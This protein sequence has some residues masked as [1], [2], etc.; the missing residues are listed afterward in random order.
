MGHWIK[1][2]Q[3]DPDCPPMRKK[4]DDNVPR[5]PRSPQVKAVKYLKKRYA[6]GA[7]DMQ[8]LAKA[9]DIMDTSKRERVRLVAAQFVWEASQGKLAPAQAVAAVQINQQV[10]QNSGAPE[11]QPSGQLTPGERARRLAGLL[12]A[13][14]VLADVCEGNA[15][16]GLAPGAGEPACVGGGQP[17]SGAGGSGGTGP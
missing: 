1:A 10:V 12:K 6:D 13:T 7:G 2:H 15:A 8:P 9:C 14:A 17:D 4:R 16:G 5:A 3:D 11:G